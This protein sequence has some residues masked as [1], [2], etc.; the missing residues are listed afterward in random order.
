MIRMLPRSRVTF[1][2]PRIGMRGTPCA[3]SVASW[4]S[5]SRN[6]G[7]ASGATS[8]SAAET[9]PARHAASRAWSSRA[10]ATKVTSGGVT[11]AEADEVGA[12]VGG[13][14][15]VVRTNARRRPRR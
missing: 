11:I 8:A 9:S 15:Q 1:T 6:A 13:A 12:T 4:R 3:A 14:M 5:R 2:A 10:N 7:G